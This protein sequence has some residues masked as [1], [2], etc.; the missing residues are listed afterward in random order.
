MSDS[1]FLSMGEID[2]RDLVSV[3]MNLGPHNL[4]FITKNHTK[5]KNAVFRVF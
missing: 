5:E 4:I 1:G 2:K 3:G